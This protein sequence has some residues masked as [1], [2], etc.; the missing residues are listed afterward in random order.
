MKLK[1]ILFASSIVVLAS[2]MKSKLEPIPQTALSDAV[3]FSSADRILQQVNGMYAAVKTGQFYGG[4][5][6]VYQDVRGEDFLNETNNGVTALQTWNFTVSSTTNEVGNL[7]NAAY[8]AINRANVV[9]EGVQASTAITDAVKA[10]YIAEARFLRALSYYSLV[11]VYARPYYDGNGAKP[12]VPLRL[13][14][15]TSAGTNDLAR[16]TVG[17]VYTQIIADL[18]FAETNLPATYG[19]GTAS[20]IL[21][22][23]RAHKNTAIAFKTRVYLS[24]QRY[25][26][27]ISEA[28]KI[29]P[30]GPPYV[31][32]VNVP[33][34]LEPNIANVFAAPYTSKESILSFPMT[35]LDVPGT[36]NGLGSYY[37][38]G[39]NGN[40]DFSV[41]TTN[42]IAADPSWKT[43][44]ARRQ[45]LTT[46]GTK[47]YLRKWPL[48]PA[49]DYVPVIRYAEVMLNLADARARLAA[50]VDAQALLL[51]NAV[52]QRSDP[53]T[54]IVAATKAE[55]IAAIERE[56]RIEFLGEGLRS[57][58][59]QRVGLPFP[60]KS[61][62]S[63]VPESSTVYI[64]PI[65]QGE[66]LVNKAA[67]QNPGY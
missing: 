56:R 47:T 41:N 11:N 44:D 66:L 38:P 12:G 22:T 54:V 67:V 25:N 28:N 62:V 37:N 57:I 63:A 50:G 17:E 27:V 19:T 40:G 55:L 43:T 8:A 18:N 30:A 13:T 16:A 45:F 51:V 32:P 7:W 65:P 5:Y 6:L 39:P 33:N 24:M 35:T 42:G 46:V 21:N 23:T 36:Q 2:C 58:D 1:N 3:A 49:T 53:S 9:M 34:R 31:S 60:A 15:Q 52:R 4:R 59:L 14:A 20:D 48:S 10:N 26:D 29:V 64:W 61:T